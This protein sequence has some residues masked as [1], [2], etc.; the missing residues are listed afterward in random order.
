MASSGTTADSMFRCSGKRCLCAYTAKQQMT[1]R[2]KHMDEILSR[3]H[4]KA[5][6]AEVHFHSDCAGK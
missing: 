3:Q 2:A 5:K 6:T 4:G 1:S